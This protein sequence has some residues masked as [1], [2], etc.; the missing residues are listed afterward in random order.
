MQ[1]TQF[2][3]N[4]KATQ[5]SEWERAARLFFLSLAESN[6]S[7]IQDLWSPMTFCPFLKCFWS[8]TLIIISTVYST[9]FFPEPNDITFFI[10]DSQIEIQ[11]NCTKFHWNQLIER[12]W[13]TITSLTFVL[14]FKYTLY[15]NIILHRY[16]MRCSYLLFHNFPKKM[17]LL[18]YVTGEIEIY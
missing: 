15:I 13:F 3:L 9:F 7:H 6:R 14:Q 1:K 12:I 2:W 5:L 17:F 10:L 11:N 8:I 18:F 4:D 16:I